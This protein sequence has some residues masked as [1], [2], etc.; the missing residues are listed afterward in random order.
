M[1]D[2]AVNAK[3]EAIN[4]GNILTQADNN[5]A[6]RA[7]NP[8]MSDDFARVYE[9]VAHRIT[10]PISLAALDAV[11]SIGSNTRLLDIAAG[12]GALS[13]QAAE[14][15]AS[16]LAVDIAPGMVK[17]LICKLANYT[18]CEARVMD[19]EMLDAPD[20]AF[21]ATFS[22]FGVMTFADWRK[23]L[24]EQARVTCPGGKGCVVTWREP[25]GGGPF[26]ILFA[27]LRS[28]FPD[29]PAPPW[30]EGFA[31][32]SDPGRLVDE[33]ERAGFT[34]VTVQQVEGVWEGPVGDAYL[35]EVYELHQYVRPYTALDDDVR[36]KVDEAIRTIT[37][38]N[39]R[40]GKVRLTS[41]VLIAV[42]KRQ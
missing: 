37:I 10:V 19:G 27:A 15:G 22:V 21:D 31:A 14:R 13:V 26:H 7:T 33:M 4:R 12:A 1:C 23:G 35:R 3:H 29:R 28:V 30:P 5:A 2:T 20:D 8:Q 25:P 6:A 39:S 11:G 17:R 40:D 38:T 24:S 34:S 18:G 42:G 9:E 41:P 16:V 32:L 36:A